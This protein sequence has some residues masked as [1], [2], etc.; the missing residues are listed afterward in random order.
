MN[1]IFGKPRGQIAVLYAGI[2]VV[3]IGAI[4]LGADVAVMYA[5]WQ[6]SQ[7]VADA[8]AQAGAN[9]LAG[10]AYTGTVGAG[11]TGD[12]AEKAACTYAVNN[13]LTA[14]QVSVT[15]PTTSTI[16]VVAKQ[17]G[18]PYFFGKVIGLKTYDVTATAEAQAS[19]PVGTSDIFPI[20]L[21]CGNGCSASSLV[22]GEP[23][24]F[25]QKFVTSVIDCAPGVGTC[26]ASGNWQW[27]D[28]GGG[29]GGGDNLLKQAIEGTA[30]SPQFSVESGGACPGPGQCTINSE[31]GNKG[32]SGP[33]KTAFQNRMKQCDSYSTDPCSGSNPKGII[34]PND[35]CL[36][37]V[38]VVNFAGCKTAGTSGCTGN[39]A[40][41][42][43]GFAQVYLEPGT[44]TSTSISG[45]YVS[46]VD[47]TGLGSIGAPAL[48]PT[49]PPVLIR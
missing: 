35:K 3:L 25:G 40:L 44:S 45:C 21:Q 34:N 29:S 7:K 33:V 11:C 2:I 39:S 46:A 13:G 5:N 32:Q 17:A 28:V 10:Y 8:A 19:L 24:T 38:P 47:P 14:S 37:V 1:K 27:L 42:I 20:G 15:E 22:G 18:L 12:D 41:T 6:Q 31:P 26:P 43:E 16:Q 49:S 48:G 9:F 30:T 23:V 4:S 36:V